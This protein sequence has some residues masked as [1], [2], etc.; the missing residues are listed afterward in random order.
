MP[1][2][3]NLFFGGIVMPAK[4]ICVYCIFARP[5]KSVSTK[6][7]TAYECGN[8]ESPYH[9]SLLNITKNGNKLQGII[10]SGCASGQLAERRLAV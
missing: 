6:K 4:I 10:W 2:R 9:K 5:D 8:S 7:W 1:I 3:G